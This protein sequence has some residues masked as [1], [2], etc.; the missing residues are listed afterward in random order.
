VSVRELDHWISDHVRFRVDEIDLPN[1][2]PETELAL[3]AATE[4]ELKVVH[5]TREYRVSDDAKDPETRTIGREHWRRADG[6]E[7]VEAWS[8]KSK[9]SKVCDHQVLGLVVAGPGRGEAFP[10]CI[11]KKKCTVH[12]AAEIKQAAKRANGQAAPKVDRAAE[13]RRYE[14]QRKREDAERARW[15]KAEPALLEALAV[16]LSEAD[17]LTLMD[18]PHGIIAACTGWGDRLPKTMARGETLEDAVR[19]AAFQVLAQVVVDSWSA[20][21]KVPKALKPFGIDAKKIVAKVAPAA[22]PKAKAKK[23]AKRK[24]AKKK[25]KKTSADAVTPRAEA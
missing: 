16:N 10:V 7:D 23:K 17:P 21:S 11:A 18:G 2:F 3:R 25:A 14:E 13:Q 20:A 8:G 4:L 19:Y 6:K 24:K 1:L 5:I 9:V 12:W 15:K 22:E